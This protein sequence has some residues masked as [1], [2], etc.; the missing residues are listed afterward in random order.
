MKPLRLIAATALL[1]ASAMAFAQKAHLEDGNLNMLK[2]IKKINVKF[3]YSNMEVGKKTEKE[4][5]EDKMEAYNK[6]EAGRGEKW[7][8]DWVS[9]RTRRFEPKFLELFND[10]GDIKG[11]NFPTEKYTMIFHTIFT[12][13][14]FN[15]GVTR[16]NAY[17]DAEI[18]I[19]ETANEGKALA[20]I[21]ISDVPG[22]TAFGGDYDTGLRIEEAYAKAGK[23]IAK[24]LEK[25]AD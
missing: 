17:I 1:L 8:K 22:R 9:D 6:K 7:A 3:D 10:N 12:E 2:G 13:P 20:K 14:G 11:G 4:Y 18:L 21:S 19:V 16:K 25:N 5:I 23:Q 15:V 24:F